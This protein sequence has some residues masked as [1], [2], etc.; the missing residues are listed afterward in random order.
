MKN[1][2]IC[3]DLL[4]TPQPVVDAYCK[5]CFAT[6]QDIDIDSTND[7]EKFINNQYGE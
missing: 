6:F 1:C 3:F 2:Q 5:E 7:L 4:P